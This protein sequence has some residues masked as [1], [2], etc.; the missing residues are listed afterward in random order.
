MNTEL[1]STKLNPPTCVF[2]AIESHWHISHFLKSCCFC[3][4]FRSDA[5]LMYF[6]LWRPM[7]NMLLHVCS[8]PLNRTGT[9]LTFRTSSFERDEYFVRL[10]DF[11]EKMSEPTAIPSPDPSINSGN[12]HCSCR[13]GNPPE[14]AT[15]D[16]ANILILRPPA[17]IQSTSGLRES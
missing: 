10:D 11:N 17:H 4:A 12:R 1:L 8:W 3:E 2:V 15:N 5:S 16:P 9:F 6:T 13:W 14:I 7:S